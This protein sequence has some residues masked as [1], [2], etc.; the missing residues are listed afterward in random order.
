MVD[1]LDS[2]VIN[3]WRNCGNHERTHRPL[4]ELRSILSMSMIPPKLEAFVLELMGMFG[5]S[6]S[7]T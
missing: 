3:A 1:K 2:F 7:S 4:R 5:S 6:S